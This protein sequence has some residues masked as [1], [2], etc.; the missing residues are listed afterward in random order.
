MGLL[1]PCN[2]LAHVGPSRPGCRTVKAGDFTTSGRAW[3]LL[4]ACHVQTQFSV[5]QFVTSASWSYTGY[6]W[7][8]PGTGFF[9]PPLSLDVSNICLDK[10]LILAGSTLSCRLDYRIPE[11]FPNCYFHVIFRS[12]AKGC[13]Q[14]WSIFGFV[15]SVVS[16]LLW[17]KL[18]LS[19]VQ[20]FL[21]ILLWLLP[22]S[23][24]CYSNSQ[25]S[26][27][28]PLLEEAGKREQLEWV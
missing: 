25:S 1:E 15:C 22:F 11:S 13:S 28:L 18:F 20:S 9:T 23:V 12:E 8:V 17:V 5:F 26:S 24:N 10:V 27:V 2:S 7:E 6:H 3:S 4:S 16:I 14:H 21:L 19:F